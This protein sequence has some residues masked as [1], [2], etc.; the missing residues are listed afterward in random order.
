MATTNI[1]ES[2]TKTF[3]INLNLTWC[4]WFEP[5]C[6]SYRYGLSLDFAS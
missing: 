6:C 2:N 3:S 5:L 1:M 4:L